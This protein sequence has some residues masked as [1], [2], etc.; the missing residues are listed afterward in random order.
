[1]MVKA[2]KKKEIKELWTLHCRVSTKEL[3]KEN[4]VWE[5]IRVGTEKRGTKVAKGAK[6][7]EKNP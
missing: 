6:L 2:R 7:A 3:A 5:R 1:M 4:A